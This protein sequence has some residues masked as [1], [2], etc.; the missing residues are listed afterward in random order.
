MNEFVLVKLIGFRFSLRVRRNRFV[1][2]P[3]LVS[4]RFGKKVPV[5]SRKIYKS[6]SVNTVWKQWVSPTWTDLN[7]GWGII[8]SYA[9]CK[10]MGSNQ[11]NQPPGPPC[12]FQIPPGYGGSQNFNAG[13]SYCTPDTP[14]EEI[15][16]S[17]SRCLSPYNSS[18]PL[19]PIKIGATTFMPN[20]TDPT[21]PNL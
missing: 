20:T 18:L 6:I 7:T 2:N 3:C 13:D 21:Y 12:R 5:E 9:I 19:C 4:F 15:G 16:H 1:K 10:S 11:S 14:G 8:I 17:W